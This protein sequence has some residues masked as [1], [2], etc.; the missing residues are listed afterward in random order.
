MASTATATAEQVQAE[1]EAWL[2]E[3]WDPAL[4]VR[5]WWRRLAG[6]GLSYPMM[7]APF[8]RSYNRDQTAAV[9]AALRAKGAMGPPAGLGT[10]LAMPTILTYGT[11]EQIEQ[12]VPAIL[13]GSHGWCQL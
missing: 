11:P 3:N 2:D 4:S 13:D 10:M 12:F 9:F 7:D 8:G 1:V 5:D 6:A